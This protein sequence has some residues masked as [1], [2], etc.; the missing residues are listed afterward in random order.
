MTRAAALAALLWCLWVGLVAYS[1]GELWP[2]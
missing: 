1:L 2:S